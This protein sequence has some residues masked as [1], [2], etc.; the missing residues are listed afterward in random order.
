MDV[1]AEALFRLTA[2]DEQ[3]RIKEIREAWDAYYGHHP[4]SLKVKDQNDPDD[5]VTL[6]YCRLIV[7]KGISFLY[8]RP[9]QID[10]G[11]G[12]AQTILDGILA[13]NNFPL[14]L[15]QFALNGGVAGHGYI[16][17]FDPGVATKPIRLVN[18][19]PQTVT[20]V[21]ADD[22]Y[23]DV[24][25]WKIQWNAAAPDDSDEKAVVYRHRIDRADSGTFWDIVEETGS[26]EGDRWVETARSK[27]PFAFS[28]IVHCQNL[29]VPNEFFGQP[30]LTQDLI[31]LNHRLNDLASNMGKMVRLFAHPRPWLKG[32]AP[33]ADGVDVAPDEVWHLPPNAEAGVLKYDASLTSSIELYERLKDAFHEKARV[34]RIATGKLENIG[35]LSGLALSILYQ[36]L[37]EKTEDKQGTHEPMLEDLAGR[38]LAVAR[39]SQ[40]QDASVNWPALLPTDPLA[41]RQAAIL[42]LQ[43]GASKK[44][45]LEALGYD[46][47]AEAKLKAEEPDA[48]GAAAMAAFDQGPNAGTQE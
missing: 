8:G 34:P 40:S 32:V 4:D 26:G 2:L 1:V 6:N 18:L 48:I 5:N 17:I 39:S 42:D 43:L 25:R 47:D 22:D 30:D 20:P 29:P 16:R 13:A 12:T 11:G 35:Q 28:P 36:P 45:I 27:W 14:L 41:E 46:A 10:V 31:E 44:T 9:P 24:H 21:W 15:K 38:I 33:G 23:Q 37:I 19:D 7:D 3:R